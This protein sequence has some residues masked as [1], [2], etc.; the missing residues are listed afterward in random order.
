MRVLLKCL[1]PP[2]FPP[3][4]FPSIASF[5]G[6]ALV[7]CI[8]PKLYSDVIR[9]NKSIAV[10]SLS[11]AMRIRRGSDPRGSSCTCLITDTGVYACTPV[12]C[13]CARCM[14]FT[15]NTHKTKGGGA[16]GDSTTPCNYQLKPRLDRLRKYNPGVIAPRL[17]FPPMKSPRFFFSLIAL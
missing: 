3:L 4:P 10:A 7:K 5:E 9:D 15:S 1:L 6:L 2:S 11:Y 8:P 16:C 12:K 14:T 13:V 17:S